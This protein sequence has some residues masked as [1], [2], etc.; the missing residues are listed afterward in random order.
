MPKNEISDIFQNRTLVNK[1]NFM[2]NYKNVIIYGAGNC[3]REVL[4]LLNSHGIQVIC[5]LD[6]KSSSNMQ[7]N[8]VSIFSPNDDH[9]SPQQKAETAIVIAVFNHYTDTLFIVKKLRSHGFKCIISFIELYYIFSQELSER[10]WLVPLNFYD[11]TKQHIISEAYNI[12]E[13]ERS[14]LIYK[15]ILEFRLTGNYEFLPAPDIGT[16][17]FPKDIPN[18]DL[19]SRFV[20]CGAFNGDTLLEIYK[21]VGSIEALAA[22]EPDPGNYAELCKVTNR[23]KQLAKEVLLWPC[24]VW[25][26]TEQLKFLSG[27]GTSSNISLNGDIMIQAV[28]LDEAFPCFNPTFIKMDIEGAEYQALLGAKYIISK[29]RPQL[30]VCLYHCPEHLWQIPMLLKQ[31]NVGYKFYLRLHCFNGFELVLYALYK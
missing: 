6:E 23:D 7:L 4:N 3:G 15:A 8:G 16:Q 29:N 27:E 10:S 20:D 22:F 12:W 1:F 11:D 31:W 18:W 25:S 5:F 26:H 24:A 21:S 2:R 17:Y 9:V 14:R 13:D 28:S 19:P 30:A